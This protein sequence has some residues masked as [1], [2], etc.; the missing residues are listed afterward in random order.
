MNKPTSVAHV[1]GSFCF[2]NVAKLPSNAPEMMKIL[3]TFKIWVLYIEK[4]RFL[5]KSLEFF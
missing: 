5:E 3:K 2:Q 1:S 4:D